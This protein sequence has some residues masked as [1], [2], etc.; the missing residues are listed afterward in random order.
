MTESFT[1]KRCKTC[2]FP[3]EDCQ[4]SLKMTN[5]KPN[6][7]MSCA[8]C[9]I[10]AARESTITHVKHCAKNPYACDHTPTYIYDLNT[11]RIRDDVI[12]CRTCQTDIILPSNIK[13]VFRSTVE[14]EDSD[15]S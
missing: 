7:Y 1:L 5:G 10:T 4:C 3:L 2:Q 14:K 13:L 12:H 8:W 15:A 9:G 11:G 6:P